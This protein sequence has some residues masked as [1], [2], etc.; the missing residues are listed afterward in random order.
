MN[1][2]QWPLMASADVHG[3]LI[4][5]THR[6]KLM[7]AFCLQRWQSEKDLGHHEAPA[8]DANYWWNFNKQHMMMMPSLCLK[9]VT[10]PCVCV[11]VCT[12]SVGSDDLL[13]LLAGPGGQDLHQDLLVRSCPLE[14][15]QG[16]NISS[17]TDCIWMIN[18]VCSS[19]LPCIAQFE[20]S[21]WW[22]HGGIS[23]R[24]QGARTSD[25][26]S[27]SQI[28]RRVLP[29][30]HRPDPVSGIDIFFNWNA[31]SAWLQDYFVIYIVIFLEQS[32]RVVS[33]LFTLWGFNRLKARPLA[34]G[35]D[36][37]RPGRTANNRLWTVS[38]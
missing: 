15:K 13:H 33:K 34:T 17:T 10:L 36:Q 29:S 26:Q 6:V 16:K 12:L 20:H 38:V 27:E 19:S 25:R 2:T 1:G 23:H 32:D 31:S 18:S 30:S 5:R 21:P 3:S 22:H 7:L 11:C 14:V 28:C 9:H 4:Q 35:S 8:Q 37:G 24:K